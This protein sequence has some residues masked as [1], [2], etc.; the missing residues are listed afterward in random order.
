MTLVVMSFLT[1][2]VA[3]LFGMF[4]PRWKDLINLAGILIALALT[5]YALYEYLQTLV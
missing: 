4:L 1:I 2:A 3:H 5:M